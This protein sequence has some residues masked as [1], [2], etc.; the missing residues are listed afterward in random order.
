VANPLQVKRRVNLC[1][2]H[3]VYL[4]VLARK[5]AEP[6]VLPAPQQSD[7]AQDEWLKPANG[8]STA[9]T[10]AAPA[11]GALASSTGSGGLRASLIDTLAS[12]G[13]IDGA[14]AVREQ[15][16]AMRHS[17]LNLPAP[18]YERLVVDQF[19]RSAR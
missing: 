14:R 18:D 5:L 17:S 19:I 8:S 11:A 15:W 2:S 3:E 10:A 1:N 16:R 13:L 4:L 7:Y 9:A 12:M 6:G